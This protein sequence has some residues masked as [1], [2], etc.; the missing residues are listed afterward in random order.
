ML[1]KRKFGG[2]YFFRR[3]YEKAALLYYANWEANKGKKIIYE[4]GRYHDPGTPVDYSERAEK[5][6][7]AY[8]KR[9]AEFMLLG[10]LDN[11][12]YTMAFVY[13]QDYIANGRNAIPV[14]DYDAFQ[15]LA[16]QLKILSILYRA[17]PESLEERLECSKGQ[18]IY[19]LTDLGAAIAFDEG[20]IHQFLE[21]RKYSPAREKKERLI[22]QLIKDI[23]ALIQA[24]KNGVYQIKRGKISEDLIDISKEPDRNTFVGLIYFNALDD[25]G[26]PQM[27]SK[28]AV[29]KY[30]KDIN[31]Y[32]KDRDIDEKIEFQKMAG[33]TTDCA[34]PT[35]SNICHL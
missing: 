14:K 18:L 34:L 22:K 5:Y 1:L 19:Y 26:N 28:S 30:R 4:G 35:L 33:S 16:E 29:Y 20:Q 10:K 21:T 25:S 24:D 7:G 15:V 31:N 2:F 8:F 12:E 17:R 32:F 27:P 3:P 23:R 9:E 13:L 11:P 6:F